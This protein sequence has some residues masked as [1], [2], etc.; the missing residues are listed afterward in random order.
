MSKEFE[1]VYSTQRTNFQEGRAYSNPRFFTSTRQGVTKVIVVGNWPK[2]VAAYEKAG[3]PVEVVS[4]PNVQGGDPKP[5]P[6]PKRNPE[7][8][9][10]EGWGNLPWLEKRLLAENFSDRPVINSEQAD[11]AIEAEALRRAGQGDG[12]A[13]EGPSDEEMRATIKEATGRAPH[14]AT[15][16]EKLLAQYQEIQ[17]ARPEPTIAAGGGSS[18]GGAQ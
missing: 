9:I 13:Q 11:T 5:G 16:R 10:P 18:S 2:V 3:V 7:A 8:E 12:R 4:G 1:L 14:P 15:G 17:A 6:A